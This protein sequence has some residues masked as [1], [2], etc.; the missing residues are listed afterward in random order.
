[1]SDFF[2]KHTRKALW[3]LCLG[4]I[5]INVVAFAHAYKFTHFSQGNS[6]RTDPKELSLSNK[7]KILFTGIDNPKPKGKTMPQRDYKV[8]ELNHPNVISAWHVKVPEAKGTV[9]LFHGYAGEKSSLVGRAKVFNDLGYN[10]FLVDFLG[11]GTSSGYSTSVGYKEADQVKLCYDYLIDAGERNILLFGTSMGAAAILK[12]VNDFN[13]APSAMMLE[14]PFGSLYKTVCARFYL[15]G[16]PAIPM[17]G[18]LT[19]WGGV[20]HGYWAFSH[21][22]S[23]YAKS[24]RAPVLLLFGEQDDRVTRAEINLIYSN[25]R[26]YK[27]MKTYPEEGHNFF[28]PANARAW[29]SDVTEFL[30]TADRIQ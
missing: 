10:A 22:P 9:I 13:L 27:I 20:Q 6:V 17:A 24:V 4:S 26:G 29:Q 15:M 3:I 16:I 7:L 30:L 8:V 21:N 2:K 23:T 11:S 28:T 5:A 1:M 14:C 12:A 25:L 19:F 18:L